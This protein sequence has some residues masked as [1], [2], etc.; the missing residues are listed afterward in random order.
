RVSVPAQLSMSVEPCALNARSE[1]V[2]NGSSKRRYVLTT[3]SLRPSAPSNVDT[4][5]IRS[6]W[7]SRSGCT[8]APTKAPDA[9][10]ATGPAAKGPVQVAIPAGTEVSA[11]G[12]GSGGGDGRGAVQPARV[13]AA[14][15]TTMRV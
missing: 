14:T 9:G 10:G 11:L 5:E 3:S 1:S 4:A 6:R 8:H 2:K 13:S 7:V 15:W 12:C